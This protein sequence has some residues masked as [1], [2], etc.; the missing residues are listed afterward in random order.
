VGGCGIQASPAVGGRDFIDFSECDRADQHA[1]ALEECK[2]RS[3]HQLGTAE[4]RAHRVA[5]FF[6]QQPR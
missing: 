3:H 2:I 4:H 5:G 1:I 6:P